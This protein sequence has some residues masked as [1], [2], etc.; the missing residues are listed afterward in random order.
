MDDKL[1]LRANAVKAA[2]EQGKEA[3]IATKREFEVNQKLFNETLAEVKEKYGVNSYEELQQAV[4]DLADKISAD[5]A[6]TEALL[7][8]ANISVEGDVHEVRN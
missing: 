3:F 8:S 5:L 1:L 2:V 6:S 7:V 4:K